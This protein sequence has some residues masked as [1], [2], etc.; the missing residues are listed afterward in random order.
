MP[1]NDDEQPTAQPANALTFTPMMASHS[2]TISPNSIVTD[3]MV[4]AAIRQVSIR[5]S[6]DTSEVRRVLG[7][8]LGQLGWEV[9]GRSN[10]DEAR[11]RAEESLRAKLNEAQLASHTTHQYFDLVGSRGNHYRI[12]TNAGTV[13]NVGWID[14]EGLTHGVYCA[15][16]IPH[17]LRGEALPEP[18]LY[19]G[20]FL[21]LVLD[22]DNFLDSANLYGGSFPENYTDEHHR[23]PAWWAFQYE[24][25]I[26]RH[27]P[28]RSVAAWNAFGITAPDFLRHGTSP[29][30]QMFESRW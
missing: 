28:D 1:T 30:W 12:R 29:L 23:N 13:G 7:A 14:E 10:P 26:T 22:E 4:N 9:V 21:A 17:D 3:S 8:T 16:P 27:Y 15:H 20:Q 25:F 19:L 2:I 5:L 24:D 11:Q 6:A 18:D